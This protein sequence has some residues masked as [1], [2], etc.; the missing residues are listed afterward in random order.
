MLLET[1]PF[2][3]VMWTLLVIFG[4]GIWLWM[5]IITFG[6]LFRRDD[7]SGWAKA[8]WVM[9]LI[10]LPFLGVLIYLVSQSTG[11][12]K[13]QAKQGIEQARFTQE[14]GAAGGSA[15][16]ASEIEKAQHLLESGSITREEFDAIKRRMIAST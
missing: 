10:V 9:I 11:M 5:L 1:Y 6:D 13:R 7:I 16:P 8:G 12:A 14:L 15:A 4:F 2:L 3:S